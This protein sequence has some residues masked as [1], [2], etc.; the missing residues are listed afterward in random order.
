MSN[1][2]TTKTS[3]ECLDSSSAELLDDLRFR[4][5]RML[6]RLHDEG[7]I[8]AYR[9]PLMSAD[10]LEMTT[11]DELRVLLNEF[12]F[13]KLEMEQH[14]LYKRH[15]ELL[16]EIKDE[17]DPQMETQL[18]DEFERHKQRMMEGDDEWVFMTKYQTLAGK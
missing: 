18:W 10:L 1:S 13:A 17:I 2:S 15:H 11:F 7:K 9:Y 5:L 4:W 3:K 16:Q 14:E 8:L 6:N 12:H